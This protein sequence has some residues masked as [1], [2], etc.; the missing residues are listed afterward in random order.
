[1]PKQTKNQEKIA[2]LKDT[3][4]ER[5]DTISALMK[6]IAFLKDTIEAREKEI[7]F[8]KEANVKRGKTI[9]HWYA[10]FSEA[11]LRLAS[12]Q[13]EHRQ[14]VQKLHLFYSTSASLEIEK[15]K[16]DTLAYAFEHVTSKLV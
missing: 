1:M 4:A 9:E 5:N 16:S 10:R 15:A 12:Q 7:G 8:L 2:F 6:E 3:I 13:E 14:E 11:D